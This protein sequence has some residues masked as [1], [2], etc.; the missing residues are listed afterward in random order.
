LHLLVD[1]RTAFD[2]IGNINIASRY[3]HAKLDYPRKQLAR[4]AD[5][6]APGP[7][8]MNMTLVSGS[9]SPNT[10][11]HLVAASLHFLHAATCS[12]RSPSCLTF[13]FIETIII[14]QFVFVKSSSLGF[15][16]KK[17]DILLRAHFR[18]YKRRRQSFMR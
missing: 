1:C 13:E 4:A 6:R 5:E 15:H 9:P 7:S 3:S 11:R 10:A 2:Y 18:L 8:P 16:E 17:R 12:A 14:I